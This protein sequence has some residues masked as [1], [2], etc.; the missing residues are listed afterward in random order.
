MTPQPSQSKRELSLQR[1]TLVI[2]IQQF[3]NQGTE[4]W[5]F[6]QKIHSLLYKQ[7]LEEMRLGL[8]L[9][10]QRWK[11]PLSQL[12]LQ[13]VPRQQND[14]LQGTNAPWSCFTWEAGRISTAVDLQL[15]SSQAKIRTHVQS[16]KKTKT[17]QSKRQHY[18]L[19]LPSVPSS[20]WFPWCHWTLM[21]C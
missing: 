11:P 20:N 9:M 5:H 10:L 7:H 3:G 8:V 16:G 13:Q 14:I 18:S 15:N 17:P 19:W 6:G 1:G 12:W 21:W 4:W 2:P